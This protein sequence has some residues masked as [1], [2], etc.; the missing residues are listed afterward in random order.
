MPILTWKTV[1]MAMEK[2]SKLDA[3]VPKSKL[4]VPPNNCI[5]SRAQMRMKRNNRSKRDTIDFRE[6]KSDTT[7]L[8]REDQYL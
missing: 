5:P 6:L 2:E 7:R 8:R 3:G 1:N 4:N